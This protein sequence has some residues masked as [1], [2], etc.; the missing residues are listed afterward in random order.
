MSW[1]DAASAGSAGSDRF[2]APLAPSDGPAAGSSAHASAVSRETPATG[3]PDPLTSPF[4]ACC[5]LDLSSSRGA[6]GEV[7]AP[8]PT[9]YGPGAAVSRETPVTGAPGPPTPP[10]SGRCPTNPSTS[11]C[12][13]GGVE[14]PSLPPGSL[15]GA[16]SRET[17][18]S[19]TSDELP[20][21]PLRG[22]RS[23]P[24]SLPAGPVDVSVTSLAAEIPETA[25]SR[26]TWSVAE[27]GRTPKAAPF[28]S[29]LTRSSSRDGPADPRNDVPAA[30]GSQSPRASRD[31]PATSVLPRIRDRP[32]AATTSS[33]RPG[34]PKA[35][36]SVAAGAGGS[37]LAWSPATVLP[38]A[39]APVGAVLEGRSGQPSA[40][41]RS[42]RS[43]P[44]AR[45]SPSARPAPSAQPAPPA[46]PAPAALSAGSARSV[47]LGRKPLASCGQPSPVRSVTNASIPVQVR[48]IDHLG[49]LWTTPNQR[50]RRD[51]RCPA[52]PART[53]TTVVSGST[54]PAPTCTMWG[55]SAPR[56]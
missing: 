29:A 1:P 40:A 34:R 8:A 18:T 56:R 3:T 37:L 30:I 47:R 35:T 52:R 45:F 12:P 33:G 39:S 2:G 48:P 11:T 21:S 16:V 25:V 31:P 10:L 13:G 14:A 55:G 20:S 44:S 19:L 4:A 50:L 49:V 22:L 36:S 17:S 23:K 54:R 43:D 24:P 27:R 42:V 38:G 53:T 41:T 5:P 51:F 28:A 7:D 9:S 32:D 15:G 46:R 26:E 6:L